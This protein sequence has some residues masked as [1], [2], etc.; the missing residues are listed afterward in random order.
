MNVRMLLVALTLLLGVFAGPVASAMPDKKPV[1]HSAAWYRAHKKHSAAWYRSH[2]KKK[3]SAAWYR[4]HSKKSTTKHSAA[5]YRKHG[6]KSDK[7]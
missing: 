7:H 2:T 6:K 1:K 4:E 3:H 5:W